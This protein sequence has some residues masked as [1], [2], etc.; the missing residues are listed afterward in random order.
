MNGN[1]KSGYNLYS[2]AL[3]MFKLYVPYL[4]CYNEFLIL[5]QLKMLYGQQL[6]ISAF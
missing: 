2:S 5:F 4:S 3:Q 6:S 1:T